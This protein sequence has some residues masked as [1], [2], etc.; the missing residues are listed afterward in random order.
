[1]LTQ[2]IAVPPSALT[3]FHLGTLTVADTV[4]DDVET[5][6]YRCALFSLFGLAANYNP[7]IEPLY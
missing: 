1:M 2:C 6:D 5:F 3:E 4:K 7:G